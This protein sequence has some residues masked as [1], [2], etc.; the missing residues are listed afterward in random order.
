MNKPD[1]A[2]LIFLAGVAFLG[3]GSYQV[4]PPAGYIVL[5]I[6]LSALGIW[7]FLK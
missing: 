7:R 3:Y 4:Y 1:L 6:V 2:D 5:G